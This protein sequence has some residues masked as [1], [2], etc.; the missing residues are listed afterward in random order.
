MPES[1]YKFVNWDNFKIGFKC[2]GKLVYKS[3]KGGVKL[4]ETEFTIKDE[5][6][7]KSIKQLKI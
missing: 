3:V 2:G 4:V 7:I 6:I 5:K 1:C